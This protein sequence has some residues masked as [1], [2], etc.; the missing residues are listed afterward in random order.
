MKERDTLS[1][2][3]FDGWWGHNNLSFLLKRLFLR[4]GQSL[5]EEKG[6]A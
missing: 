6:R 5:K 3:S 4:H 1:R 2:D